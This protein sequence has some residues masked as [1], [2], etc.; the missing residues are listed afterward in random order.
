MFDGIK[1]LLEEL[2]SCGFQLAIVS[3][4]SEQNI[5]E[6]LQHNQIFVQTICLARMRILKDF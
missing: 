3:T 6:C 5:R 2:S 4:N 1:E